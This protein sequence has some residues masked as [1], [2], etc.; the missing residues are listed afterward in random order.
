M[1]AVGR[2]CG[3]ALAA[4]GDG[5]GVNRR[6][7]AVA[8][9]FPWMPD[10]QSVSYLERTPQTHALRTYHDAHDAHPHRNRTDLAKIVPETLLD[11]NNQQH[12][13]KLFARKL[14]RCN[15]D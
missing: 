15:A 6:R 8:P 1:R 10:E 11:N 4:D 13:D 14:W 5:V 7:T 9:L 2:V 3:S 12:A